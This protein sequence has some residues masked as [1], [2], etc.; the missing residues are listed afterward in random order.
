MLRELYIKNMILIDELRLHFGEGLNVL[1]GETGTGKSIVVDCLE[2]LIGERINSDVVRNHDIKCLVEGVF[3]VTPDSPLAQFLRENDLW[4]DDDD[5]LI[6]RREITPQGRTINRVN[7]HTVTAVMLKNLAEYLVDIHLQHA[8]QQVLNPRFHRHFLDSLTPDIKVLVPRLVE[9]YHEWKSTATQIEELQATMKKRA[10]DLDLT[11]NQINEIESAALVEGEDEKLLA[12]RNRIL[13]WE[14][15]LHTLARVD[16]LVF[17]DGNGALVQL[18]K[19]R[20]ALRSVEESFLTELAAVIDETYYLLEDIGPRMDRFRDK[21][22]YNPARLEAIEDRL[23]LV[24]KIKRKYGG[25][26][27]AALEYLAELKDQ[28][29]SLDRLELQTRELE[30]RQ[31]ALWEQYQELAS[32]ISS[33]RQQAARALEVRIEDELAQLS[34]PGVTFKIDIQP[35]PPTAAGIDDVIFQFSA[36]PGEPPR[37]VYKIASGGE[38]SRFILAIKTAL[39]DAYLVPVLV[40]DEIDVGIG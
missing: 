33:I 13:N 2:L 22:D 17:A 29:S 1:T 21:Q 6:I 12:E 9:V 14:K 3:E 15:V 26:I 8:N 27:P 25:T 5:C 40:F 16:Q 32:R 18:A 35:A 10:R 7:G 37:P 39:A 11:D 30:E 28:R 34:M 31:K 23:N 24:N 4:E 19:A 36:N 38:S 20:E